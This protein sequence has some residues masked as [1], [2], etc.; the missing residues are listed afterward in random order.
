M[1]LIPILTAIL[2]TGFLYFLVVERDRLLDFATGQ[3]VQ[4]EKASS[5]ETTQQA[6]TNEETAAPETPSIKV[7]AMRSVSRDIDTAVLL[8]GET[9]A[10]RQVSVKAETSGQVISEP[11]RKGTFVS[12]AQNLCVLDAGT[13]E[14]SLTEAKARLNEA[15]ARAPEAQAR[16]DE[17]QARL[18]EAQIND[19]AA[20]RL[21]EGG[22]ASETRVASTKATVRSAQAAVAS[23]RSGLQSTQAGIESAEA[24]VAKVE[25]DI[26]NL[27][28][29]APFEGLLETDTAELGSLMQPGAVCATII[30][31][32][33]IK[34]VGFVPETQV[35]RVEIGALAG[36]Q[37]AGGHQVQ[38]RVTFLSRS[39]DPTTR[40][41]RVEIEVPNPDL[42]IR[43][44]QTAE[45]AIAAAG[46]KAHVIPQSALTLN[47]A[48]DLGVRIVKDDNTVHFAKLVMLRDDVNGAWVTGLP[49]QVNI[50]TLGQEYV[51]DG[52]VVEPTFQETSQ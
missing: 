26:E 52:I 41:F 16:V 3:N 45:I 42:T 21:S 15:R 37:L 9:E 32:D 31:L 27:T 25:K 49:E 4:D 40:T 11:L 39:A 36:A 20:S 8:R 17:A 29:T 28:I 10:A 34:V 6:T 33:P 48:G 30:Q 18:D 2:V 47:D 43:D 1:R 7:M 35:E 24:A 13:R 19:N 12:Q 38:G 51:T 50:I 22:F 23:A 5:E 44:G 14:A 46:S